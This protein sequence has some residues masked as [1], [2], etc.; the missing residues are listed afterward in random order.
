[1]TPQYR[2]IVRLVMGALLLVTLAAC[3]ASQPAAPV[4]SQPPSQ[5]QSAPSQANFPAPAEAQT[6]KTV[7][8]A[9]QVPVAQQ[10]AKVGAQLEPAQ[11]SAPGP[12]QGG[13]PNKGSGQ[14]TGVYQGVFQGMGE[15]TVAQAGA[16]YGVKLSDLKAQ[17]KLPSDDPYESINSLQTQGLDKASL[18]AALNQL[19]NVQK[20]DTTA[21]DTKRQQDFDALLAL[22]HPQYKAALVGTNQK[23]VG[24]ST[25]GVNEL[26]RYWKNVRDLYAVTPPPAFNGDNQ[27]PRDLAKIVQAVSEA[28]AAIQSGDLSKGHEA[29]EPVREILLEVR[30]RNGVPIFEDQMTLFHSVM[31]AVT[32]PT[33][34]KT[35]ETLTSADVEAVKAAYPAMADAFKRIEKAP[36]GHFDAAQA[37]GYTALVQS[38]ASTIAALDTA[39][40]TGDKAAI[41]KT[42]A[43]LKTTFSKLFAQYG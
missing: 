25:N 33:A 7:E 38:E 4:P 29:L 22:A 3:A 37:Q 40:K 13:Q 36:D 9:T 14:G 39:L 23:N 17:V 11:P 30:T 1:M 21:L 26:A 27:W 34:N 8:Q 12:A 41:I 32:A 15:L 6:A 5:A 10:A 35:V 43:D 2:L 16:K 28:Q 42:A 31:E 19:G 18:Q 24:A 20:P